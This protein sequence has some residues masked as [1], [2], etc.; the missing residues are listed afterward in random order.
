[1]CSAKPVGGLRRPPVAGLTLSLGLLLSL[2]IPTS[3]DAQA[4]ERLDAQA[5]D[6][7]VQRLDSLAPL[8][9][10]AERAAE[11]AD[12]EA[13]R[14]AREDLGLT[15][16]TLRVGPLRIVTPEGQASDAR[17]AFEEVWE[18]AGPRVGDA[19]AELSET[20]WTF[21]HAPRLHRLRVYFTQHGERRQR[22]HVRSWLPWG[23]V[24]RAAEKK[25]WAVLGRQL[26]GEVEEVISS[27]WGPWWPLTPERLEAAHRELVTAPGRPARACVAGDVDACWVAIGAD[28]VPDRWDEWYEPA[29]RRA[30]LRTRFRGEGPRAAVDACERGVQDA[31]DDLL[32]ELADPALPLSGAFRTRIVAHAVQ[33]GGEGGYERLADS[34]GAGLREALAR[35]AE[36]DADEVMESWRT[37]VLEHRPEVGGDTGRRHGSTLV[38]LV[39]FGILAM[40]STRWRVG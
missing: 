38:W 29:E 4:G 13:R 25:V 23:R 37:R 8:L 6:D 17:R 19:T 2:A 21:Q 9:E 31:C 28:G 20:I 1:M 12:R 5:V 18:D 7:L 15:L 33:V 3:L 24:L 39:V 26:E 22:V 14:R 10:Q 27:V 40:G 36:M 32:N 11:R 30:V 35:A 16:D 34:G